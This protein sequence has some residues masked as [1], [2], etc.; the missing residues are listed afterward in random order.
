MLRPAQNVTLFQSEQYFIMA[1]LSNVVE[2]K[3]TQTY[4]LRKHKE[5]NLVAHWC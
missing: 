5:G 3:K 1:Q 4:W 2:E